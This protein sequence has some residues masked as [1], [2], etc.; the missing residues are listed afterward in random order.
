MVNIKIQI[1]F[2]KN[3]K[4]KKESQLFYPKFFM[5][6]TQYLHIKKVN[7]FSCSLNILLKNNNSDSE[8]NTKFD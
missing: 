6:S 8:R 2:L 1:V 7:L 5:L 3:Q 4:K